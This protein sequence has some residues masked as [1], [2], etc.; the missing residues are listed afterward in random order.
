MT[1]QAPFPYFGGKRIIADKI[2]EAF[3]DVPNYAEPFFGSGAVLLNRPG[4]PDFG[5]ETVNDLDGMVS[6][7]WRAIRHDPEQTAYH[8]DWPVNENDL[9]A[10]HAWLV[11]QKESLQSRLEGDPDYFDTKIAGW[12][13]WGLSCWIGS[14]FCSG[15]GPWVQRD[16]L[17]VNKNDNSPGSRRQ[18]VYLKGSQGVKRQRVELRPSQGVNRKRVQLRNSGEGSCRPTQNLYDWFDAL[19][20]RL[21]RVR[22]CCG[23]WTRVLGPSPTFALGL[24]GVF[25][26]PPYSHAER[27]KNLYNEDNDISGAVREW[28]IEAGK[29]P[30]M[31]VA[32]C[33]YR[34]E[35]EMPSDWL[36]YSWSTNGGYGSQ[37]HGRG[38][39]NKSREVVWFSPACLQPS[40]QGGLL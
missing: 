18:L 13:A 10:R 20:T 29:N 1:L 24:T 12:W 4:G 15:N 35:Y 31:R 34:G 36:T 32:L 21:R 9:S 7:F 8:A 11:G 17:L 6:N 26:D 37:G 30:L 22:V 2:W 39:E 28:A 25:L 5:L 38:R 3:G 19:S 23:D 40:Q 14:G 27:E 33:G 16:G